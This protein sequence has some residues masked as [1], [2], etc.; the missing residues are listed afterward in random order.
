MLETEDLKLRMEFEGIKAEDISTHSIRRGSAT[1]A[2]SGSTAGPSTSS[3]YLRA[4][5]K[6][7][8]VQD[9]YIHHHHAGDMH[10]G[11]IVAGLPADDPNFAILPPFFNLNRGSN[12]EP[13]SG[14]GSASEDALMLVES[15]IKT[16][17]PGMPMSMSPVL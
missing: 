17:F 10:V 13:E 4:G 9:R 3:V 8:G 7:G 12:R 5:W 14:Q 6:L 2:P 11:R 16:V 1:Y 15:A